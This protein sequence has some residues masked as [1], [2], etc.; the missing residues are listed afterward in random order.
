MNY[1]LAF[2]E[3]ENIIWYW[4]EPTITLDYAEHEFHNIIKKNWLGK[5]NKKTS[6]D[7]YQLLLK[8]IEDY[9]DKLYISFKNLINFLL[10]M[11]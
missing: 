6:V 7:H 1:M 9:L 11:W 4:D 2:N 5:K 8:V 10:L 3:P